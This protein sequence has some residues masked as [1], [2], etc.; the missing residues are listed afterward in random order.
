[1]FELILSQRT[2]SEEEKRIVRTLSE[3]EDGLEL[4]RLQQLTELPKEILSVALENLM[5]NKL[6]EWSSADF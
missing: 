6:V 1:M 3:Y 4:D 5:Y 2:S